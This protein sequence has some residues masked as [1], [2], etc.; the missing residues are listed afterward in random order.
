TTDAQIVRPYK[1]L[2]VPCVRTRGYSSRFDTT[3]AL[4]LDTFVRPYNRYSSRCSTTDAQ[5]VR[6]YKG[7][8][9]SL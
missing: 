2:L 3:D 6:P 5:I 4:P 7:L 9:V 1:G 8:H